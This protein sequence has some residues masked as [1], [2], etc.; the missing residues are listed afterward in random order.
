MLIFVNVSLEAFTNESDWHRTAATQTYY[1]NC[2]LILMHALWCF[3]E[4]IQSA[5][6]LWT[7]SIQS[8]M[9]VVSSWGERFIYATI[10]DVL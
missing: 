2:L 9:N 1:W 3:K 10:N 4:E 8:D 5:L 6:T 7:T